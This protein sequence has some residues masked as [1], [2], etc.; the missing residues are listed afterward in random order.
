MPQIGGVYV[1][2]DMMPAMAPGAPVG[3]PGVGDVFMASARQSI[4]QMQ[5]GIPY[6]LDKIGLDQID[7]AREAEYKRGLAEAQAA[8]QQAPGSSFADVRA[9]RVGFGRYLA[10]LAA[11]SAPQMIGTIASA[12]AGGAV[13]GP[14]G[15][16]AAGLAFN[17]P[18]FAGSNVARA[19]Q[20]EGSL[21]RQAAE[22]SADWAPVQSATDVAADYFLPGVGKLLGRGATHTGRGFVTRTLMS[23]GEAGT[24][25]AAAEVQ[26]QVGER[27]AAGLPLANAEAANE[28]VESAVG[29]FA[30]GGLLGSVGG[31]RRTPATSKPV[32]EVN[33][34]DMLATVDQILSGQANAAAPLALPSPE[35]FGRA[36]GGPEITDN[37]PPV[38][39]DAAGRIAPGMDPVLLA[40]LPRESAPEIMDRSGPTIQVPG[41]L[42]DDNSL[43]NVFGDQPVLTPDG[44]VIHSTD[45]I[46]ATGNVF[47]DS[48]PTPVQ[49]APAASAVD[50]P[51]MEPAPD[52]QTT[53][54]AAKQGLK[55]GWVQN[56]SADNQADLENK[57]FDFANE[58][59]GSL[60]RNEEKFLQRLGIINEDGTDFGPAGQR[61]A[62]ER[63]SVVGPEAS[64]I[65]LTDQ[66]PATNVFGESAPAV[67]NV[68]VSEA[69]PAPNTTV[70]E[71][72]AAPAAPAQTITTAPQ[73]V[74]PDV[75]K[76]MDEL[77]FGKLTKNSTGGTVRDLATPADVFDAL[78]TDESN[79]W[80]SQAE[81]L[82]KKLGLITNDS[83]R[84]VT[85]KGRAVYLNTSA[86]Q[87]DTDSAAAEHALSG[88]QAELFRQGA[89]VEGGGAPVTKFSSFADADAYRQGTLWAQDFIKN[90]TAL[91]AKD[92]QRIL[93]D[94]DAVRQSKG[95][96]PRATARRSV[97]ENRRDSL[98]GLIDQADLSNV[99]DTEV[100]ELRRQAA[101]GASAQDIADAISR[102]QGGGSI[103]MIPSRPIE[104]S[105]Y[106]GRSRQPVFREM[107]DPKLDQGTRADQRAETDEAL[108]AY[109]LRNL[110]RMALGEEAI[111]QERADR[112]NDLLDRGKV[113]QVASSLREFTDEGKP[114]RTAARGPR[115]PTPPEKNI[116]TSEKSPIGKPDLALEQALEGKDFHGVLDHMVSAA[117][118]KYMRVIMQAVK[119]LT[120]NL[121]KAGMTFEVQIAHEGD[122]IPASLNNPTV[123]A[124]TVVKLNPASA[125]VWLKDSRTSKHGVNYQIVAHE[126]L[127]AVAIKAV[128]WGMNKANYGNGTI[129]KAV[130]D[131]NDLGG[132]IATHLSERAKAGTL[133]DFEKNFLVKNTNA[134]DNN[135]ELLAW[136]MTNPLVQRYLN[137]IQ[138]KPRQSVFGRF[139]ELLRNLLGIEGKYDT[140]LTELLRVADQ[141]TSAP[142]S[143][144]RTVV[145]RNVADGTGFDTVEAQIS[146][147]PNAVNRTVEA[148][149]DAL[150]K[151]AGAFDHLLDR[152]SA[153]TLWQTISNKALGWVSNNHLVREFGSFMP[154]LVQRQQAYSERHAVRARFERMYDEVIQ[155]FEALERQRPNVA[156]WIG[157]LMAVSTEFQVDGLKAWEEHK[158]LHAPDKNMNGIKAKDPKDIA[159]EVRM[160]AIHEKAVE[161]VNNLSRE[162]GAGIALYKEMRQ[163]NDTQN[164]ARM[165]ASLHSLVARDPELKLGVADATINP[166]DKFMREQGLET[167]AA[168]NAWWENMLKEQVEAA[169][170][171]IDAKKTDTEAH[172]TGADQSAMRIRLMP[173]EDEIE[174]VGVALKK[175]RQAPYFHLGRFGNFFGS[176]VIKRNVDGTVD[177]KAQDAVAKALDAAGHTDVQIST[178]NT[179]PKIA[180]RFDTRL[181][182]E[183]FEQLMHRLLKEGLIEEGFK[184]G[185]RADAANLGVAEAMPGSLGQYIQQLKESPQYTPT[186]TMSD[187]DKAALLKQRDAAIQV[188]TD[189]WISSQPDSSISRVLTRRNTIP[190]YN[191]DMIRNFAHRGRVGALSLSN[192]ASA[193]KF[194]EAFASM[195]QQVQDAQVRTK[196]DDNG[197]VT[198][199]TDDQYLAAQLMDEARRR[200]ASIPVSDDADMIDKF[201]AVTNTYFLGLSPAYALINLT[202]VGTMAV[203]E[204]AKQHGYAKSF[205]AV[206]VAGG[207]ALKVLSAIAKASR[208]LG[209]KHAADVAITE[210]VLKNTNLPANVQSFIL[211]MLATGTI[212][213][214]SATR[215]LGQISESRTGSKLDV[216]LRYASIL[217]TYSETLS[218]LTAALAAHEL[219]GD[220][221]VATQEY[222]SR[223][224]SEAMFDY[225]SDN[226]ARKLG[227][228]GFLGQVTPIVTQFMTYSMQM[229]EKLYSEILSAAGKPRVGESAAQTK[230]R[231][232]EART[233]LFGH[234]TAI[235]ALAGTLGLP[236]ATVFASVLERLVDAFKDDDDEPFDAT[237]A[238]RDFLAN[239]M[240]KDMAEVV[241]RGLPRAVGFDIS[242]RAGEQSLL[243][244]SDF[245]ADRRPWKDAWDQQMGRSGGAGTSMVSNV[246]EGASK[247][248]DGD[249]LG[250]AKEMLPTALK[251]PI[252]VMR[253]TTDGYVDTKGNRLPMSPG[254]SSLMWQLLG[255]TPSAK[256][257]YAEAKMEQQARRG[258][259]TRQA[260]VL[261]SN[262]IRAIRE[263]DSEKASQLVQEAMAFDTAHPAFAVIPQ[264]KSTLK[265][266][267]K[268][269][270]TSMATHTPAGV[271]MKDVAGQSLTQ[272]ANY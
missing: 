199:N 52:F 118:S 108:K 194:D 14:V 272:Y 42:T 125:K 246:I 5:Y 133:T 238:Y 181:Q 61:I 268:A 86:G 188:I 79:A 204:L 160:K 85:P 6:M 241:A 113:R 73:E 167:S 229:T 259:I 36:P 90:E 25:E 176:A 27:H 267:D 33:N 49:A 258:Q 218:R 45:R 95:V 107:Y 192:V 114:K 164:F 231:A 213:I 56:L 59:S 177:L 205:R 101:N 19:V 31:F 150:K 145:G 15:A 245:L 228:N 50:L 257:E 248:A 190:G 214:A 7:P 47:E 16:G 24:A 38:A 196:T 37:A 62:A 4:G 162:D 48:A 39:V 66:L 193:P 266:Q 44:A 240:G 132:A 263:H 2:D 200:D 235:T 183:Q 146:S 75:K 97:G 55:G 110:S 129:G 67:P 206:R 250:G 122:T 247:I 103:K 169:K 242:N 11:S 60:K 249:L 89:Q 99:N 271:S 185:P 168:T 261:S 71:A 117:P 227:K 208:E 232:K 234:L 174:A 202:Q 265:R 158:H 178:D 116:E 121:E 237:V 92:T 255:F 184:V 198:A 68:S 165:A 53:L 96:A 94:E 244:F 41:Q 109:D 130:K 20:E 256:A 209:L 112:L 191:K 100:A 21:S 141:I 182:A 102:L 155:K 221:S 13:G 115:L 171:F 43:G 170:G 253:M 157:E 156:K 201:R 10:D 161:L 147:D 26:Q 166:V 80:V 203:P 269:R 63:A 152:S 127:H 163:I 58:N 262:I 135:H 154:G 270:A 64:T 88:R 137:S 104:R 9:G 134:L 151:A 159:E 84:D 65:Q 223:L 46:P 148:T 93:K 230:Q 29:A 217:G 32:N 264:L 210:S 149:T 40:N 226:T 215:S 216:G 105:G 128:H 3:R 187:A 143:D 51:P 8:G 219:R 153:R 35:M 30:L 189:I 57:A 126:L 78:A 87:E 136:G 83:A 17:T 186:D 76:A 222:A 175:M 140:A 254:A 72:P 91:S 252:E 70:S 69:A 123:G 131:L 224:V 18:V 173:L 98:N 225:R 106:D 236:F 28:Y 179:N 111:T 233:F 260:Q 239:V 197:N 139:V 138:Y 195:Q 120:A 207:Q 74:H 124:V 211:S 180:L 77:G 81:Q 144:L 119:K 22:R 243:P 12:A 220:N 212:D 251:N 23:M 34:D 142:L 1:P 54:N 82:A 172:G